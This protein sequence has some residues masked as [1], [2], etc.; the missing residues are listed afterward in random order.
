MS[1]LKLGVCVGTL[2]MAVASAASDYNVTLFQP[3]LIGSKELKPG[4]YRVQVDGDKATIKAGKNTVETAVKV[5]NGSEK[6]SKT[7]VKYNTSD[8][9]YHLQE[10]H[11]AGTKTTL[12][13][14]N[15]ANT[16]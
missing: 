13:F 2:A 12:I 15:E 16:N 7:V 6:F 8:G 3:S 1:F 9:K 5:E 11:L 14:P 10:I 4:D